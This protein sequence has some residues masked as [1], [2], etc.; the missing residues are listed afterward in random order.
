MF[1]EKSIGTQFSL[2]DI[3]R[4]LGRTAEATSLKN[5]I[6]EVK[7]RMSADGLAY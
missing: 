6:L 7:D 1:W 4:S 2:A 5:E 3:Y